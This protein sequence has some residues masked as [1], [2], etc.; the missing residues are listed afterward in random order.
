MQKNVHFCLYSTKKNVTT[1][2]WQEDVV[3]GEYIKWA[4]SINIYDKSM[5]YCDPTF[6]CV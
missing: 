2:W 5:T 1:F 3:V 6:V 4:Q